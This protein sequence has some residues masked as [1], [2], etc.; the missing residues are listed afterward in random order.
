MYMWSFQESSS[1]K[2]ISELQTSRDYIS[3][4]QNK[5]SKITVME[6]KAKKL[7]LN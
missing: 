5:G 4:T 7:K 2:S 6:Y 1:A 3:T